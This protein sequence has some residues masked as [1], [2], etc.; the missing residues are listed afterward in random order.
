MSFRIRWIALVVLDALLVNLAIYINLLLR[1]DGAIPTQYSQAYWNL[2]PLC[3]ILFISS[4]I[5]LRLYNRV[6][7][8]ASIGEM[9]SILKATIIGMSVFVIS[10][11]AFQLKGLP[12]SIY[13]EAWVFIS[14]LIGASRVCWRVSRD[15]FKENKKNVEN[16]RRVL[17]IGAGDAGAILIKETQNNPQLR[18]NV[19][20]VVDDD[21]YKKRLRLHDVP[22]LGGRTKIFKLVNELAIDEIIIAMPSVSGE[23]IREIVDICKPTS[24]RL[25]I[26]PGI[27]QGADSNLIHNIRDVQME[28]LLK[29][30]PV[31]IDLG[32]IAGYI[33][34]KVVLVTGAGGSIGS[35][36]CRQLLQF[37]PSKLVILDNSENSLFEIEIELKAMNSSVH[38]WTEL[39]DVRTYD[40]LE[41]VFDQH[42]PDVVFHA[43]AYKHVPMM[44]RHPDHALHNNVIGTRNTAL[45]A[46]HYG[47]ETF[48]LIS[49]DKAVNPT[50]IMGASKRIAE[51]VVQD[52]NRK[53][54][55]IFAAVRFGNVLGSRGSVIPTFMKQI[56]RGGPV[57]VTHPAMKRYFMTIPEAV[58]LVI[59]AGALARGGETF[60]LDMGEMIKIE[61]LAREL[62]RLSGYEP[63]KDIQIVYTGM[64]PGE[65]LYEE[66][67]TNLEE[68]A[69]TRHERIYISEKELDNRH[70]D[71]TKSMGLLLRS[72]LKDKSEVLKIIMEF[73]PEYQGMGDI[74]RTAVN[75]G[76]KSQASQKEGTNN[77]YQPQ[78]QVLELVQ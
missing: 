20:G 23:A 31:N 39:V 27:Y 48:I 22:I 32:E 53:S 9:F 10:I 54:E 70:V 5:F 61:D 59:E 43:A 47:V 12:R 29:R 67:F 13:F 52:I 58:Q 16:C 41:A 78:K 69:S 17:V 64:R 51:M 34:D 77:S 45:L 6:W 66:L 4:F 56:E 57:T 73:V 62:I 14:V 7:E 49:T 30:S 63:D 18:L 60:V 42:H 26:L 1:F 11:Y 50:S 19:V 72:S 36:L 15:Y 46:D 37:S 8:Y 35:E 76:I 40:R 65:K 28:D 71:L 24:A 2:A 21:P 44:Q 25:R 38:I 75:R 3:T 33:S 55:T 74:A 68:M